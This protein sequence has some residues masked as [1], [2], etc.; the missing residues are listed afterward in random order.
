M[1]TRAATTISF[2]KCIAG[3][4]CL[5]GLLVAAEREGNFNIRFEPTAKLQTRVQIPFEI[6][7]SDALKKALP[8]AKVT[9]QIETPT[10]EHSAVFTAPAVNPGVYLAKPIFPEAGE[11]NVYVEVRRDDEMSARTIAFNVPE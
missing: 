8:D 5:F 11:W 10:H 3:F 2:V 9:L 1:N 4:L 7:V 6:H